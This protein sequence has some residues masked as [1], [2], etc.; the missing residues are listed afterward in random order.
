[1]KL[2]LALSESKVEADGAQTTSSEAAE[3]SQSV[4]SIRLTFDMGECPQTISM[5]NAVAKAA[6]WQPQH[7]IMGDTIKTR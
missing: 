6:T 4:L 1:M 3:G 2:M 5:Q 7:A